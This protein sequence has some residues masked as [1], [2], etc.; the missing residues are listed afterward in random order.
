MAAN[1]WGI[2]VSRQY[3]SN[4]PA[5]HSPPLSVRRRLMRRPGGITTV[6]TNCLSL[7]TASAFSLM[8]NTSFHLLCCSVNLLT[9]RTPPSAGRDT[10]PRRSAHTSLKGRTVLCVVV[11]GCRSCLLLSNAHRSQG[12]MLSLKFMPLSLPSRRI[13]KLW[14]LTCPILLCQRS[15]GAC[16]VDSTVM[17]PRSGEVAEPSLGQRRRD[18][19]FCAAVAVVERVVPASKAG[20]IR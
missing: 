3:F 1:S 12:D 17:F 9:E 7:L 4:Y 10:G 13:L 11:L 6:W 8:R 2:P 14:E 18:L 19:D 16:K 20:G 15:A 5:V